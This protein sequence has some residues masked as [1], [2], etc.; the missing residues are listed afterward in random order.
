MIAN[1]MDQDHSGAMT[2]IAIFFIFKI[3]RITI[4]V[5]LSSYFLGIIFFMICE[6]NM[7]DEHL[8]SADEYFIREFK[9]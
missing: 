2:K 6:S 9:F 1:D 4:F 5:I 8:D 3:V 7:I